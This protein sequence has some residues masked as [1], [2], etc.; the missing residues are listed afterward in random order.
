MKKEEGNHVGEST[1]G[2]LSCKT[3]KYATGK[4]RGTSFS[5]CWHRREIRKHRE[6]VATLKDKREICTQFKLGEHSWV[7]IAKV[8]HY[9]YPCY[10]DKKSNV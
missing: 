4:G 6:V 3:L 8:K 9:Y 10:T 1:E 5:M 7:T 2:Q